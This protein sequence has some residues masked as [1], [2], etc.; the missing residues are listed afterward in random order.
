MKFELI[1][2]DTGTKARAGIMTTDHGVIETPIFMPVATSAAIKGLHTKDLVE[3][4]NAEIIL[5]NTY[6]LYLR[7][8]DQ[9]IKNCGGIHD[10]M[11]WDKL[12][13]TD[14]GGY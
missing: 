12:V 13:L 5:A 8:G 11:S 2:T 4:S 14:S 7:P 9:I 10:F 3:S 6:H 1:G